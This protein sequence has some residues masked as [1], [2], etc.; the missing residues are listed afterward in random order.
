M[1]GKKQDPKLKL[2][3]LLDVMELEGELTSSLF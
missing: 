1:E 2:A 3:V